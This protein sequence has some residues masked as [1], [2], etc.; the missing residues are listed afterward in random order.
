MPR[1]GMV[2]DLDR[3]IG[4]Y[5]CTVACHVEN[6]TPPGIWYAPV[7]EQEVGTFPHVKR[8]FLP[9]LC[10]HCKDAPCLKSCPTGAISRRG[11]GIVLVN[12]DLCCGSRAC[13]AACPYGAMHF[14]G[15]GHGDFE[16]QLTPFER[17][18]QDKSQVGTVQKCTLC[19][20]RIDQGILT[21]ACVEACPTECRIF[22]DLD[23]PASPPSKLISQHRGFALRPEAGTNPS[24]L[25]VTPGAS[26]SGQ[27]ACGDRDASSLQIS[28]KQSAGPGHQG[29]ASG[30]SRTPS[31]NAFTG[32]LQIEAKLQ[33][34][35]G[36]NHALWFLCMGLGSALYLNRLLFG[37]EVGQVL[38]L[39][40]ADVLGII[41]VSIGGLILIADLG[42]P[43]RFLRALRNVRYS[44]ISPGAIADFVFLFL[45]GLLLLPYLT[46]GGHRP[47]AGF[48]WA[49][50]TGLERVLI[51]VAAAAA[52]FIIV[53][54]G[55]VLTSSLSI[56]FWNTTLIPLQ[57]FG[58]A[59]A[60]A[61]GIAYLWGSPA[62]SRA[63]AVVALVSA[64]AT[65]AFSLAHIQNARY[66]RGAA[67]M[68]ADK[69]MKGSLAPHFL[70]G[71][72][73]LGLLVPVLILALHLA[74]EL[75]A[76]VLAL[77]GVLLL[78]GNFLSKYAVIKAGYYASLY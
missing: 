40:L 16:G 60:S 51:W 30:G 50:G 2:L 69:V 12:Q 68:S 70:W 35:W 22:G 78:A 64:L 61:A 3:C 20:H 75:A 6:G 25:Y 10:M 52:L 63:A 23:D 66:Q 26:R 42:R 57:Y 67:R 37:I 7:Y 41:L 15:D 9:T 28:Q 29:S 45:G 58:S 24:I 21:P 36:L 11:D 14:Y 46:I 62:A 31:G 55:L 5:S 27:A 39:P 54:P 13:V 4:C 49:P 74:S 38:G 72:L 43:L 59:L 19:V 1:W 71:N 34:V 77:A 8:V 73:V 56:P 18:F 48:P 44:W 33:N 65:L 32:R 53:Y 17:S 76:G 47:L